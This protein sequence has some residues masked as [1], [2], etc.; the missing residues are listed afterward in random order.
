MAQARSF[1]LGEEVTQQLEARLEQRKAEAEPTGG[2]L[3]QL[4]EGLGQ[5]L[6][7]DKPFVDLRFPSAP[8]G[9]IE[10][11]VTQLVGSSQRNRTSPGASTE[12]YYW[13]AAADNPNIIFHVEVANKRV[14]ISERRTPIT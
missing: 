12:T 14:G 3:T 1:G 10:E 13:V 5:F 6:L 2:V 4:K 7:G 11:S 9:A 8:S